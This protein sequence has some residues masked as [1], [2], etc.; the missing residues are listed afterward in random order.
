MSNSPDHNAPSYQA[1]NRLTRVLAAGF[2]LLV[3]SAA[4]VHS[5]CETPSHEA[6]QDGD[7][8]VSLADGAV[9][10][11]W[12]AIHAAAKPPAAPPA[13]EVPLLHRVSGAQRLTGLAT[14]RPPLSRRF[15][16]RSV[17]ILA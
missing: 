16:V 6:L 1:M 3:V 7:C 11:V 2:A 13:A 14:D 9:A 4:L 17:R 8:C 5:L 10:P 12:A 15:H